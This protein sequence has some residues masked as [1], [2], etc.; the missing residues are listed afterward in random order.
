MNIISIYLKPKPFLT[1]GFRLQRSSIT[2]EE[3]VMGENVSFVPILILHCTTK[4]KKKLKIDSTFK[5]ECHTVHVF[6]TIG[7]PDKKIIHGS[8]MMNPIVT[9]VIP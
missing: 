6:K 8:L 5:T 3:S 9:Y 7:W 1:C 2:Y 4:K